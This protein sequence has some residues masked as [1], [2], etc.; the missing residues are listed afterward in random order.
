M[1]AFLICITL[2]T[3]IPNAALKLI[4][5]IEKNLGIEPDSDQR[6]TAN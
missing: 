1:D 5:D 3:R 6:A 4:D 2:G